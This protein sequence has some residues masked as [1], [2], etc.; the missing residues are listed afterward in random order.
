V[1]KKVTNYANLSLKSLRTDL[2]TQCRY[3][4]TPAKLAKYNQAVAHYAS[5]M[6]YGRWR[7]QES[8]PIV[9]GAVAHLGAEIYLPGDGHT[10]IEAARLAGYET[11]FCEVNH[12]SA[13]DAL[14]Y[15]LGPANRNYLSNKLDESDIAYRIYLAL[16]DRQMWTWVDR[17]V[18]H[19]CDDGN[20]LVKLRK[21]ALIR[22]QLLKE[23][24]ERD[25]SEYEWR[26]AQLEQ[27]DKLT[28]IDSEG[29]EFTVSYPSK[30]IKRFSTRVNPGDISGLVYTTAQFR[31]AQSGCSVQQWIDG[32]I[33]LADRDAVVGDDL[34]GATAYTYEGDTVC[35]SIFD[36]L[37]ATTDLT[38]TISRGYRLTLVETVDCSSNL[39]P[40]RLSGCL[41]ADGFHLQIGLDRLRW[42]GG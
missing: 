40:V 31:A 3:L 9:F 36:G 8:P 17:R 12:G 10:R 26:I 33:L 23:W 27:K 14:R 41:W 24:S 19:Y 13:I 4:A 37:G 39:L 15:S 11:I 22:T 6:S 16:K 7:W 21:V 29:V 1:L 34:V 42:L 18:L 2:G 28:D 32:A 5:E 35:Y 30:Q 20:R 38:A 25:S